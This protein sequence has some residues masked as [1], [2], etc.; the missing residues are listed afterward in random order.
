[1]HGVCTMNDEVH[2]AL[3]EADA[4]QLRAWIIDLQGSD[5]LSE[6]ALAYTILGPD[7]PDTQEC[8]DW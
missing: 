7:H 2:R 1:M 4:T 5:L 8:A 3:M 6:Y